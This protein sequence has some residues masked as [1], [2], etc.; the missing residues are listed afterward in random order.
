MTADPETSST[1]SS[2]PAEWAW[3]RHDVSRPRRATEHLTHSEVQPVAIDCLR[4]GDEPS[5]SEWTLARDIPIIVADSFDAH[6][7]F[8]KVLNKLH[9]FS[10]TKEEAKADLLSKLGGHL[11]LLRSLE[12]PTMAPILRLELEFLRVV[13]LPRQG[14]D[15]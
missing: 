2:S 14:S 11:R 9:G 8:E 7:A 3:R 6:W 1:A 15:A 13:L 10:K 12:S 4:P 5:D